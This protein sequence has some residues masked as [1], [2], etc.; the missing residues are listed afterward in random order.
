MEA[1]DRLPADKAEEL[2]RLCALYDDAKATG[3]IDLCRQIRASISDFIGAATQDDPD[4]AAE[5]RTALAFPVEPTPTV[6]DQ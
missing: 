5:L 4:L 1:F 3:D 6:L 2:K